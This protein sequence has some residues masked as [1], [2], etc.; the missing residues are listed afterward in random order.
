M[1]R[2]ARTDQERRKSAAW[3]THDGAPV[4]VAKSKVALQKLP[5]EGALMC[6][7]CGRRSDAPV[8]HF[9]IMSIE[10]EGSEWGPYVAPSWDRRG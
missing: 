3:L 7:K 9:A 8:R 4:K 10:C 1:K 2:K 6:L 5:R